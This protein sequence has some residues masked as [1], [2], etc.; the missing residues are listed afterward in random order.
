MQSPEYAVITD[1]LTKHF[2][3][4]V[5]VDAIDLRVESGTVMSLLGPNG[6]GKTTMVGCSPPCPNRP[7][8]QH[9]SAATTSSA[10]PMPCAA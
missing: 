1:G 9:R 2:G 5:A 10:T 4:L 7:A 8:A 3:D 6:A